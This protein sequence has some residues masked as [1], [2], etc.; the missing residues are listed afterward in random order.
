MARVEIAVKGLSVTPV[1][2]VEVSGAQELNAELERI[3]L[4]R[5][6]QTRSVQ[7]SNA[8]GWHSDRDIVAWGGEPIVTILDVAKGVATQL[9]ADRR[10]VAVQPAWTVQ[11]WA[12]VNGPG[13]GNICHC[14]PVRSGPARI[15]SRMV[16]A[17]TIRRWTGRSRC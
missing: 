15:M 11:V 10:G 14:H 2:A 12:K 7:A 16:A 3:I 13:D 4:L 8:G 1:A 9:T 5:R 17:P 6:E